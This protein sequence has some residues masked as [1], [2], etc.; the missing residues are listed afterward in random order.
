[1]VCMDDTFVFK[2]CQKKEKKEKKE[3]K[4]GRVGLTITFRVKR[5]CMD[6]ERGRV[7][8]TITFGVK[9]E[10]SYLKGDTGVQCTC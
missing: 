3:K 4:G 10:Q 6:K 9:R 1:M 7:G 8:L 5:V 2:A